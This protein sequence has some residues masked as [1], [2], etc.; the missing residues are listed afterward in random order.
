M[1]IFKPTCD[2][3]HAMTFW[4][5]IAGLSLLSSPAIAEDVTQTAQIKILQAK[6]EQLE[7]DLAS[8]KLLV[9][10]SGLSTSGAAFPDKAT[11]SAP[12]SV[13]LHAG[14]SSLTLSGDGTVTITGKRLD[15]KTTQD[16]PI[17]GSKINDN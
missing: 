12:N 14:K 13:S 1:P 17:R 7:E 8:L 15:V 4:L 6:V 11:L 9:K 3:L 10:Q 16:Q 2:R 5:T